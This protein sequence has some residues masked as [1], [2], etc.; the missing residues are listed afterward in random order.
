MGIIKEPVGIDFTV[1]SKPYTNSEK[2]KISE[3]IAAY[4]AKHKKT[5]MGLKRKKTAIKPKEHP[6]E[7]MQKLTTK[8]TTFKRK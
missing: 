2:Q 1:I 8:L 6:L 4:K 7:S 3:Y 5:L